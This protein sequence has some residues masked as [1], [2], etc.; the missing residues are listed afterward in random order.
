MS[1]TVSLRKLRDAEAAVRCVLS[2]PDFPS[3]D[4]EARLKAVMDAVAAGL[5]F[6]AQKYAEFVRKQSLNCRKRYAIA[7]GRDVPDADVPAPVS[8]IQQQYREA[9]SALGRA[10]GSR[11]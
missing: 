2:S 4:T 5:Q 7:K 8:S 10:S 11:I 1:C 6:D 3:L 9:A